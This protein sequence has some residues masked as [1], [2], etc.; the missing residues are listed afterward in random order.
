MTIIIAE[1]E[2]KNNVI[3]MLVQLIN[4]NKSNNNIT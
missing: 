3:E 1:I 2:N 4:I